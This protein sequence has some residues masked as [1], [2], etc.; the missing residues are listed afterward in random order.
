MN[1]TK[2]DHSQELRPIAVVIGIDWAD[3]KHDIEIRPVGGKRQRIVLQNKPELLHEWITGI[4]QQYTALG[5]IY[6]GVEKSRGALLYALMQYPELTLF[7]LHSQSIG[8]FRDALKASGAKSDTADACLITELIEKH[9]ASLHVWNPNDEQTRLLTNLCEARRKAVNMATQY[10]LGLKSH[11]KN[12]FPIALEFLND[13]T[14][15]KLAADFL[16]KWPSLEKL[17]RAKLSTIRQFF[18]ARKCKRKEVLEELLPTIGQA[19]SFT[20]DRAILQPAEITITMLAH[21]LQGVLVYIDQYNRQINEVFKNHPDAYLFSNL[22]GAAEVLSPRLLCAFGSDRDRFADA[23][24]VA[25]FSGI[26]PV[27]IASGKSKSVVMRRACAKFVRQTLHEFA[28]S[29]RLKCAW[30]ARYYET[31]KAKGKKHQAAVRALAFKWLRILFACWK[32]RVAYNEATYEQSLKTR[33]SLHA[34]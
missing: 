22:P 13:D 2:S 25:N 24:E 33:G 3:Q 30:A 6:V 12:L 14:T 19:R 27:Q 16:S 31:Q 23:Q 8:S 32:K 26:A 9:H 1:E 18:Y 10:A 4:I 17:Q 15:G 11:L 7:P 29:S 5:K 21:Q 20:E 34:A 28:S